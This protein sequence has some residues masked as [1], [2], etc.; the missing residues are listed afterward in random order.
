MSGR[1]VDYNRNTAECVYNDI[2]KGK[3]LKGF[4]VA[5]EKLGYLKSEL[6]SIRFDAEWWGAKCKE[7]ADHYN[8]MQE[9]L[10]QNPQDFSDDHAIEV[11]R[12]SPQV[13]YGYAAVLKEGENKLR[14]AI[15]KIN[16]ILKMLNYAKDAAEKSGKTVLDKISHAIGL[17]DSYLRVN[18]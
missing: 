13:L 2:R 10:R 8:Y 1:N 4:S 18:F 6:E 17:M 3:H 9:Q 7:S 15:I 16:D 14:T 11:S 12:K 5:E